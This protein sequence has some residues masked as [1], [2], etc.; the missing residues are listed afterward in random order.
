MSRPSI[1]TRNHRTARQHH[2]AD[3]HFLLSAALLAAL[4]GGLIAPA[5]PAAGAPASQTLTAAERAEDLLATLSPEERVGQLIL[6]NFS[7]SEAPPESDIYNLISNYHIGGV[8][9]NAAQDNFTGPE[10]TVENAYNLIESLQEIEWLATQTT[11]TETVTGAPFTPVYVPLFVG[12]SQPGDGPPYD[13]IYTGLTA[14]PSPAAIGATWDLELSK[15][16]GEIKGREL[17]ALGINLLFGPSLDVL[18]N[19]NPESLSDLGVRTFG[20]DPFWVGR[21]GSAH[22]QGIH[23]GS[24]QRIAVIGKHFPGIGGA[25]RPVEEEVSTVR[26]SLEQLKQIE[27]APFFYVTGDAPSP[28]AAVDGLLISHIRYQGFLGNIRATTRP[29]S[30]DE[31]S[32]STIM[33]LEAFASWR[34]GGGIMISDDLGSRAVRRFYDP[35]GLSFNARL[36]VRDAFLAGNDMLYLGNILDTGDTN[37]ITTV[38]RIHNFFT[39]KYQEDVEFARQVDLAVLR[40]LTLK[41]EMYGTFALD[42]VVPDPGGLGGLGGSSQTVFE[43]ARTGATLI[44]PGFQDLEAQL[45]DAPDLDDRIIF[46]TDTN[47]YSQCS[48]C[49]VQDSLGINAMEATIARLYGAEAG[50]QI[51]GRNLTSYTFETLAL[52]LDGGAA[53]NLESDLRS[54]DWIVIAMQDVSQSRPDS[55][56]FRRLLA[57]RD[58][59]VRS[60]R[61]I[62]FAFNAPYFLDATDISKVTAYYALYSKTGEAVEI[63][64]R[65]LFKEFVPSLGAS[66]V[67]V[68][69]VGY[70]LI[71][72]MEPDPA[73][74]I[75]LSIISPVIE[76]L[77]PPLE[78]EPAE[79]IE[80]DLNQQMTLETSVI[81]DHN[82]NP[83]PDGTPV[84][85]VFLLNGVETFSPVLITT[86]GIARTT[87][88][89]GEPGSLQI[90]LNTE[91][92]V[93]VAVLDI[94]IPTPED[95]L[96]PTPTSENVEATPTAEP[97][98]VPQEPTPAATDP[99]EPPPRTQTDLVDWL[100]ACLVSFSIGL[101]VYRIG[102]SAGL[103]RWSIRWAFSAG[104]GGLLVYLYL[105]L[106][107]NG[108]IAAVQGG[109]GAVIWI[110]LFGA[111]LGWTVSGAW[112][113]L[114][115]RR[116]PQRNTDPPK[117]D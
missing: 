98:G 68:S 95:F 43:I 79:P 16:A 17:A 3:R 82:G 105:A 101:L 80:M 81:T 59:L 20:G 2:R 45:P 8:I 97:T 24:Q 117:V 27:L 89:A 93:P 73:Q 37:P 65:I 10:N 71:R 66:P 115:L 38:I 87:Y 112:Y 5:P 77:V 76:A 102:T 74:L 91:P 12:L 11:I 51:Q 107:F 99:P 6:V 4:L 22:I 34:A 29:I 106:G 39:Q 55:L 26:K 114:H 111:L 86:E 7:G 78:Q 113:Q 109:R 54:A 32:F 36:V 62:V 57:E 116:S 84:Q 35:S 49:P 104:I 83:V 21:M 13:Q 85:F 46:I 42:L 15:E 44:S 63:A 67:S 103:T 48:E 56:A 53:G 47:P 100:I 25:D 96:T 58:D 90:G 31:A 69:G 50:N 33:D 94:F 110:T 75:V 41:F 70:D 30:F 18:E 72:A 64:A 14:L 88:T 1:R 60:K 28:E 9:L 23:A 108:A 40:I 92:R 19:P 52:L 61:L